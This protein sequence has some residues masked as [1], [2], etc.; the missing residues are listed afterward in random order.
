M[1]YLLCCGIWRNLIMILNRKKLF[2]V[3][4]AYGVHEPIVGLM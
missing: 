2:E 1:I 4:S 3:M